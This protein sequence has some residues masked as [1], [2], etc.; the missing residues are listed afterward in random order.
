[1]RA[2]PGRDHEPD[3]AGSATR[4]I[5][6]DATRCWVADETQLGPIFHWG[7]WN[8]LKDYLLDRSFNESAVDE[9][10]SPVDSGS[11]AVIASAGG[12]HRYVTGQLDRELLDAIVAFFAPTSSPTSTV[13]CR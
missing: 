3:S 1:V 10:V 9:Q 12:V 13:G 5:R 2:R 11:A 7:S 6:I 4:L 8:D